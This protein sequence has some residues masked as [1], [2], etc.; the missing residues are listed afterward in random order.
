VAK[1]G[2]VREYESRL[3]RRSFRKL[4]G[5]VGKE[6]L[7]NLSALSAAA[8]DSVEAALKGKT[9]VEAGAAFS[10]TGPGRTAMLAWWD[11]VTLGPDLGIAGTPRDDVYAA[12]DW[13][14]ER[15]DGIEAALAGRHLREGGVAMFDL[16]SSWVE[17]THCELA[18]PG[19][20][21]GREEGPGAGR[22]RAAHRSGGSPRGDPGLRREYRRPVRVHRGRRGGPRQV[23][24]PRAGH[25]RRPGHDYLRAGP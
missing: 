23:R 3:L 21:P 20:L 9:L 11:D 24:P 7:A 22:V 25:G 8:V 6:T 14:L 12:M 1:S 10:V 16:F 17:G 2:D 4:D 13:Q 18:P 19:L 15:Q 5:R